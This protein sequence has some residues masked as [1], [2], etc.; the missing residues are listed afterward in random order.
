M[1]L[2]RVIRSRVQSVPN[3]GVAGDSPQTPSF[4]ATHRPEHRRAPVPLSYGGNVFGSLRR[5]AAITVPVT[6]GILALAG[7]AD[8]SIG[9]NDYSHDIAGYFVSGR[10]VDHVQVT[11]RLPSDATCKQEAQVSP[12]GFGAAVTLGPAEMST[13]GVPQSGGAA[14]TV[15]VSMVPSATTGCG[16]ISPSFATNVGTPTHAVTLGAVTLSPGNVVTLDLSY[17]QKGTYTRAVVTN[18][19]TGN[20]AAGRFSATASYRGASAT[21]GFGAISPSGA[22]AQLWYFRN[23]K[24]TSYNNVS[25]NWGNFATA[26]KVILTGNGAST[27]DVYAAPT[28]LQL[29]GTAFGVSDYHGGLAAA[30]R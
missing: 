27:G 8:A 22:S 30:R 21:G 20:A 2:G 16:V 17:N 15:G 28:G 7:T 24:L 9:T 6:V 23:V 3:P 14:S 26:H 18:D 19:T 12:Q 5:I 1:N 4:P 25:G 29:R 13:T 11:F 10:L